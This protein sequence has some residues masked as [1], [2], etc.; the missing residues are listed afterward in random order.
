VGVY[1]LGVLQFTAASAAAAVELIEAKPII[2]PGPVCAWGDSGGPMFVVENG[3]N[4][5]ASI[6]QTGDIVCDAPPCNANTAN[7]IR[8]CQ[9]PKIYKYWETIADIIGSTWNSSAAFQLLDVGRAEWLSMGQIGGPVDVNLQPWAASARSANEMCFNRGFIG[10][11]FNGHQSGG[12][13]GLA[14]AGNSGARWRDATSAEVTA[15]PWPFNDVN[16]ATWA[17]SNRAAARLCEQGGFVGGHFN[18][19]AAPAPGGGNL[20]GLLCY[21]APARGFEAT[22]GDFLA[23][24]WRVTDVNTIDWAIAARAANDFCQRRAFSTGFMNGHQ[25]QGRFGVICH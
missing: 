7:E 13:F 11:H 18:G 25:S 16:G 1:R 10:G 2:N 4:Q 8:S 9:G 14:C 20:F 22:V 6:V 17:Q 19:F 21:G 12:K 23:G 15:T 5:V 24:P 3:R